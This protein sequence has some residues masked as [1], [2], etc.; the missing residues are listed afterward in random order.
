MKTINSDIYIYIYMISISILMY[1]MRFIMPYDFSAF[2]KF[3]TS[4]RSPCLW[5][6]DLF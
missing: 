5:I 6:V 4:F 1:T 2:A 3:L